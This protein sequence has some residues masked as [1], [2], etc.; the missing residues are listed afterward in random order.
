MDLVMF[1]RQ[2]IVA[3]IFSTTVLAF[4]FAEPSR[5]Q[6]YERYKPQDFSKLRSDAPEFKNE[7]LSNV[8]G[9]DRI[10]VERLDAVILVDNS[11]KIRTDSDID[12][13]EGLHHDFAA[14]DSLVFTHQVQSIVDRY[15]GGAI[16]LRNLNQLSRDLILLYRKCGQPI[17]DV[18]IPEQRITGGTVQLV[19]VETR[20]DKVIVKPGSTFECD[21]L[22][23]WIE[24]TRTGDRV[25][26]SRLSDDLFWLNQNPFRRVGVDFRKGS[27]PGTTDVIF[28][29]NDVRPIRGYVGMDDSG[30]KTLNYGRFFTGMSYGNLF[31]RGGTLG[32]QYTADQEFRLLNAHAVNLSQPLSREHSFTSYGSWAAVQPEMSIV[33][34]T[35]GGESWQT[36]SALVRH[37]VRNSSQTRNL[38]FGFD[39]KSTNNNLEFSGSTVQDSSADLLQFRLGLEDFQ[40]YDIDQYTLFRIDTFAGPGGGLTGAHSAAA[41]QTLRAGTSPDYIY[42]RLS[43]EESTL[44]GSSWQLLGRFT[45]Q[46]ASERLLFSETLGIGGHD[47]LRGFDPNSY[48]ADQGWI[49]NLEFG[50]RTYRWGCE[51]SPKTLRAFSFIDMANGHYRSPLVGEDAYT[52]A[53]STGAGLRYQVSDRLVARCDYGYG[54]KGI[55][56]APR[57]SRLHFGLTWIPGKR[58]SFF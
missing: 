2:F 8:A 26:E 39:F 27:Q 3:S 24:S 46:L 42:G 18:I 15:I 55:D 32:Y 34:L 48:N 6:N 57:D 31:G 47:T 56:S 40:R 25:H 49:G 14:S 38:A 28:Q 52:F 44:V 23:R 41:F 16:T 50:P 35:Q 5:A 43:Y 37:L 9:D 7:K 29:S 1:H 54:L 22:Q 11:I 36:G 20:I 30:V 53:M 12:A 19:V 45:G 58:P 4:Y 13:I 51:H 10:L 17:V 21:E 33:G